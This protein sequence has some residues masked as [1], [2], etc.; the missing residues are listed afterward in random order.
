[1]SQIQSHSDNVIDISDSDD[2]QAV[3]QLLQP[4]I[5][6]GLCL[7]EAR[8]SKTN[9]TPDLHLLASLSGCE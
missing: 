3:V 9:I 8:R 2:E 1:M 6:S 7:R 4:Q 5:V